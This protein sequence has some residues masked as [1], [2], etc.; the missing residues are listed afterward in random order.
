MDENFEFDPKKNRL[1][2]ERHGVDLAWAQGLWEETHVI[3]LAKEVFGES[4]SL[5]LAK[6]EDRCYVAVFTMRGDSIRLISC[7]RADV[8]L[9]RIYESRV[10]NQKIH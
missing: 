7:H 2:R 10:Q 6:I 9:E 8:R 3:I 4:R 1:N 5:I